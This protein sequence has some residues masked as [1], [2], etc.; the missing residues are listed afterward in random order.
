M[1]LQTVLVFEAGA[2]INDL[3]NLQCDYQKCIYQVISEVPCMA[4]PLGSQYLP[5]YTTV[6]STTQ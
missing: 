4:A 1:K 6:H 3:L 5:N 2:S